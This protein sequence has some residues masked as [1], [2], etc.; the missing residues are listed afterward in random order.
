MRWLIE[1]LAVD[2]ACYARLYSYPRLKKREPLIA[3]GC[4]LVVVMGRGG[5]LNF[6]VR[7]TPLREIQR[8]REREREREIEK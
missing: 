8:E 3:L 7:S 5:G 2:K 6:C 4:H 1:A